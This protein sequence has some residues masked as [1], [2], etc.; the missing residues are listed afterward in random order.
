MADMHL[1]TQTTEPQYAVIHGYTREFAMTW[2]PNMIQVAPYCLE[3]LEDLSRLINSRQEVGHR[4][5]F[6]RL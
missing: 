2:D 3:E 4:D 6:D 5:I 1:P